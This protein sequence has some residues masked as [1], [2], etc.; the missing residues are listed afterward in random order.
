MAW[1]QWHEISA[2]PDAKHLWK[3][4]K[5]LLRL[6]ITHF[7]LLDLSPRRYLLFFVYCKAENRVGA[8]QTWCSRLS[9]HTAFLWGDLHVYKAPLHY[10]ACTAQN[11][12]ACCYADCTS[13]HKPEN[14]STSQLQWPL[15][16]VLW[17]KFQSLSVN[18]E[19]AT[20]IRSHPLYSS[21]QTE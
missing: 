19:P 12:W 20:S 21:A 14:H 6:Y 17:W 3:D 16:M 5:L 8:I 18:V 4:S 13:L 15:E 10:L 11:V 7:S 2:S 1:I 9:P